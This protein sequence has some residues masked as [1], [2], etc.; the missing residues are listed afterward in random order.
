MMRNWGVLTCVICNQATSTEGGVMRN[1]ALVPNQGMVR[2]PG[3]ERECTVQK[4]TNH[5]SSLHLP[6]FHPKYLKIGTKLN[7]VPA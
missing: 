4:R 2:N 7:G 1:Y 3:M 6:K 5:I